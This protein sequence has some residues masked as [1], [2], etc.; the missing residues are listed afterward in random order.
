MFGTDKKSARCLAIIILMVT[1]FALA[2]EHP[3]VERGFHA[4]KVYQLGGID[5]VNVFNGNVLVTP[6]IGG[7]Y[8]VSAGLSYGISARYN[9]KMWE[10]IQEWDGIT[11]Q[12]YTRA[13]LN[14]NSNA[15]IG[16]TISGRSTP[17][18]AAIPFLSST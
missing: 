2:Q 13:F 9:L 7:Q 17:R 11:Q 1:P 3:T 6:P 14:R 18:P 16:W 5:S 10:Y 15:G 8:T 4:D 12:Y